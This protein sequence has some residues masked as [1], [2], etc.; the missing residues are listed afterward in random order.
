[1]NTKT[2]AK[3]NKPVMTPLSI[4]SAPRSAPTVRSSITV[5]GAGNAPAR[6][7]AE[8]SDALSA[9]KLPIICPLPP[10]IGC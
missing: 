3:P 6:S 1:M 2:S 10:M 9:V 7:S 8:R 4:A 5:R